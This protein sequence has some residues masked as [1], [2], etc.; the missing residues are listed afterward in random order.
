MTLTE[1]WDIRLLKLPLSIFGGVLVIAAIVLTLAFGHLDRL[2]ADHERMKA[3]VDSDQAEI[4]LREDSL[5]IGRAVIA[6]FSRS[7][8]ALLAVDRLRWIEEL[9]RQAH[10]LGLPAL[11]YSLGASAPFESF[12]ALHGGSF[13]VLASPVV[14]DAGLVH[15]GQ[16]VEYV[17][18]LQQAGLGLFSVDACKLSLDDQTTAFLPGVKNLDV[19]CRLSWYQIVTQEALAEFAGGVQ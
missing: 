13:A 10:R 15:E 18:R 9:P 6:D 8:P 17:E 12:N 5:R 3:V 16:W 14:I 19:H 4:T 11:T 2:N 7:Y 1:H